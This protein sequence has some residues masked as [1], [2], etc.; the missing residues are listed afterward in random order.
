MKC[1][2]EDEKMKRKIAMILCVLLIANILVACNS[3]QNVQTSENGNDQQPLDGENV[4]ENTEKEPFYLAVAEP[5]TGDDA[6]YGE[7]CY[8]GVMIAVNEFNENGGI[9]GRLI[10]VD[11]F[12]DKNE[13]K[14]AANIAQLIGSDEKYLAVIGGMSSPSCLASAPIY[15]KN[16]LVQYAPSAGH[17]DISTYEYTWVQALGAEVEN[18]LFCKVAAEDLGGKEIALIYLNNDNG[19]DTVNYFNELTDTYN[20]TMVAA[21]GYIAGQ[22]RDFTPMLT[23]IKAANPDILVIN[24]Q[25]SDVAAILRQREQVG[26]GDIKVLLSSPSYSQDFLDLAGEA[27]EGVYIISTFTPLDPDPAVQDFCEKFEDMVGQ[28]PNPFAQQPYECALMFID[29][30]KNGAQTRDDIY[31]MMCDM[32]Y[33]EGA[34]YSAEIVEHRPVRD[35]LNII[36]VKNGEFVYADL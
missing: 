8:A 26:L 32:T 3:S 4:S 14:E 24:A 34:T 23:K 12:D 27:A 36:Q 21:E 29:C 6:Q 2:K 7:F 18:P 9:D 5:F 10:Q 17:M 31:Q 1:K 19:I 30:L 20:Y 13:P 11:K 15:E 28:Q 16:Q 22:V 35:Q 33:W 25:Y